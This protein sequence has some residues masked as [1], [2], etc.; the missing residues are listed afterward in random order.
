MQIR[1]LLSGFA[2]TFLL[3]SAGRTVRADSPI[4][5]Q[6]LTLSTGT[7]LP[8]SQLLSIS[9]WTNVPLTYSVIVTGSPPLMLQWNRDGGS[10]AGATNSSYTFLPPAGTHTY[11]LVISNAFGGTNSL[12]ATVTGT[13]ANSPNATFAVNFMDAANDAYYDGTNAN[14]VNAV[15]S[16]LGAYADAPASTNWNGFGQFG[17]GL[18]D[19]PPAFDSTQIPQAAS[20]GT[21]VP[22]TLTVVY[23][24]D[25]GNLAYGPGAAA[26]GPPY[27]N[28][29]GNCPSLVLGYAA[30]VNGD[31]PVGSI[32]LSNVP[33]GSYKLFLF[34]ANFDGNRGASFTFNSG[35]PHNGTNY[36]TNP[37]GPGPLNVFTEGRTYVEL[38]NV[39]PSPNGTITGT[40]GAV[41]NSITHQTGEGDFNGLQLVKVV[42]PTPPVLTVSVSGTSVTVSWSPVVGVLQSA[43]DLTGPWTD[44]GAVTSPYV[45]PLSGTRKFYRLRH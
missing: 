36:T 4:I 20:D 14:G 28:T 16:G 33:P 3:L 19:V 34:G 32:T 26:F 17:P 5:T 44:V 40:F 24:F 6:D 31:N 38:D 7:A 39:T 43:P 35:I 9:A 42:T 25:N 21:L 13:N 30:V 22:V 12:T 10:I 11:N 2:A 23:G 29:C 27:P 18:D 15:Y 8:N 1:K 41:S 45:A 37:G